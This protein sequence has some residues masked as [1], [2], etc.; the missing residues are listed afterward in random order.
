MKKIVDAVRRFNRFYTD[1]IG[2]L[3]EHIYRSDY[4]LIEVRILYEI[5]HRESP[6]AAQIAL[7]LG[8]DR[9]YLSRILQRLQRQRIIT[10]LTSPDDA[11]ASHLSLT[12]KGRRIFRALDVRADEDVV[13][14]LRPVSAENQ[15]RLLAAMGTIEEVLSPRA[16]SKTSFLF[17]DP[18]PGDLGWIVYRHGALYSQEHHYDERYEALVAKIVGDFV[19]H[20]DP[21]RERCWIA[22]RDGEI[23][24]S[25]F[26]VKKSASVA[27]LRLLYVEPSARGLG[28]GKRLVSECIRF[29]R[30]ARYRKV[31]LGTESHLDAA[32]NIYK[33]AGF[34]LTA[35]EA[36][37]SY[38]LDLVAET[39]E[40]TL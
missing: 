15:Q 12:A 19:D 6:T 32:R 10:R 18:H 30:Q 31:T 28:I 23:V 4:S 39:W 1:Q 38:G 40:L 13:A 8:L 33:K 3:T 17:R 36:H 5:E 26:L 14:L 25:V 9:G 7:Y 27:K 22:E 16:E 35:K 20:F 29:A 34:K 2:V 11:R 37:N 24:G 21:R